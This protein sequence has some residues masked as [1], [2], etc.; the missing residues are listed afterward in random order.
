MK[1]LGKM[2]LHTCCAPC[3]VKCVESFRSGGIEPV[4]FFNNPNI[5]PYTEYESRKDSVTAFAE[6]ENLTAIFSAG[7]NPRRFLTELDGAFELGTRCLKCYETRLFETA[8]YALENGFKSFSTTLLISPYQ[9]HGALKDI[10]ILAGEKFGVE[11]IYRDL[12]SLFREGQAAARERGF[13][14]QK[15]CGCIFSEE[16]RYSARGKNKNA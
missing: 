1:E 2:L 5:Q 8:R 15:Y 9:N 13:Y 3:A 16:E 10:G 12:R 6:A 4:L 14:M 7:Y 11:F